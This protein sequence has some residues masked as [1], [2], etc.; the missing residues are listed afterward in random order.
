VGHGTFHVALFHLDECLPRLLV[1]KG[2][3]QGNTLLK[4]GLR[5]R[6]TAGRK[7]HAPKML[8]HCAPGCVCRLRRGTLRPR[9]ATKEQDSSGQ[10]YVLHIVP[11]VAVADF[12]LEQLLAGTQSCLSNPQRLDAGPEWE[13]NTGW[14][15]TSKQVRTR[16]P[17]E[18]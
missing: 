1:L 12:R 5:L 6:Q 7:M 2:V 8:L 11:H 14:S 10:S 3:Q 9:Q 16:K 13:D 15:G 4:D 18:P 17:F